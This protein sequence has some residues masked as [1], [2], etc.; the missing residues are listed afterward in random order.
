MEGQHFRK[1]GKLVSLSEQQLVDCSKENYGCNGG[2]MDLAF[3][4]I[5]KTG[6]I[7]GESDY[8]Y[9]GTVRFMIIL[10]L[11]HFLINPI[12]AIT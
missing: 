10:N 1:K 7:E 11:Y 6:G 9:V 3:K 2:H 12:W 8:P 4:Y 5:K